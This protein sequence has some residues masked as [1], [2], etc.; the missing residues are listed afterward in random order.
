MLGH[1]H[2]LVVEDLGG[3]AERVSLGR[4]AWLL[5]LYCAFQCDVNDLAVVL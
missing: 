1:D 5:L 4:R 3:S 2:V